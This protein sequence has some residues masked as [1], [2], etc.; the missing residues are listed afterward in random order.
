MDFDI[1]QKDI[2]I[3]QQKEIVTFSGYD[4]RLNLDKLIDQYFVRKNY[5]SLDQMEKANTNDVSYKFGFIQNTQ[6]GVTYDPNRVVGKMHIQSS[7][8]KPPIFNLPPIAYLIMGYD[9]M[10]AEDEGVE[11]NLEVLLPTE[12]K[13]LNKA[14]RHEFLRLCESEQNTFANTLEN[15]LQIGFGVNITYK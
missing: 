7:W 13:S 15:F 8:E 12:R 14:L 1:Q 11:C 6:Q 9:H 10:T 3:I 2:D 5:S 4:S